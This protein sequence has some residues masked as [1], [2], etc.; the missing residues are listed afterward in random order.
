MVRKYKSTSLHESFTY[1]C[2]FKW[3]NCKLWVRFQQSLMHLVCTHVSAL[4][5]S[6]VRNG[7]SYENAAWWAVRKSY[8]NIVTL[9]SCTKQEFKHR[10]TTLKGLTGR[11]RGKKATLACEPHNSE[12]CLCPLMQLWIGAVIGLLWDCMHVNL[13]NFSLVSYFSFVV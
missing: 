1:Q 12:K 13:F 3:S 11:G 4:L 5:N 8:P 2:S 6:C 7:M 9:S 10:Y